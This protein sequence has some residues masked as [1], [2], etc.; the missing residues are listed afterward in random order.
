MSSIRD[1]LLYLLP[2]WANDIVP[3]LVPWSLS[4]LIFIFFAERLHRLS[5]ANDVSHQNQLWRAAIVSFFCLP[6]LHA[7]HF[8]F[9]TIPISS[10]YF[11]LISGAWFRIAIY[12]AGAIYIIGLW[13][14]LSRL[15]LN[16][17]DIY[18]LLRAAVPCQ[19]PDIH[20]VPQEETRRLGIKGKIQLRIAGIDCSPAVVYTLK[21]YIVL[22]SFLVQQYSSLEAISPDRNVIF[23]ST[24]RF[25]TITADC[26]E[27]RSLAC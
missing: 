8:M 27:T 12:G 7:F 20:S 25:T 13:I 11:H 14:P 5:R 22:P 1:I 10:H 19:R 4:A 17:K 2:L 6:F 9:L 24:F 15:I 16:W 18:C 23:F 21:T 26:L 3:S